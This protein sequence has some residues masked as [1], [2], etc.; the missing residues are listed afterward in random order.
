[1]TRKQSRR[2]AFMLC[3]LHQEIN[4]AVRHYRDI[5]CTFNSTVPNLSS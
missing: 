5:M 3:I 2:N 4:D 1:M